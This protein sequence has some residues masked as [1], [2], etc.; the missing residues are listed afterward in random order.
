MGLYKIGMFLSV[1]PLPNS[2]VFSER[3]ED[4]DDYRERLYTEYSPYS[5]CN[6][7]P[8]MWRD[9]SG[10]GMEMEIVDKCAVVANCTAPA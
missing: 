3:S 8:M 6:N 10:L 4:P 7:S 1:D 5:Y 9:P 2:C